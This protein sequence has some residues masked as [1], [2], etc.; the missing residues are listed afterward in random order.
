MQWLWTAGWQQERTDFFE[1][2]KPDSEDEP[3]EAADMALRTLTLDEEPPGKI[4]RPFG[5][6]PEVKEAPLAPL[7]PLQEIRSPSQAQKAI[8]E[9]GSFNSSISS[10]SMK[11]ERWTGLERTVLTV[12][13]SQQHGRGFSAQQNQEAPDAIL[14]EIEKPTKK[15]ERSGSDPRLLQR[16]LRGPAPIDRP[17]RRSKSV[18]H[19]IFVEAEDAASPSTT[20]TR[21]KKKKRKHRDAWPLQLHQ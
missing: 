4:N 6:P 15:R 1:E 7:M 9:Q 10:I 12:E 18:E 20:S 13:Q 16:S 2:E 19:R 5:T 11:P 17:R 21:H 8:Q 3:A 14:V